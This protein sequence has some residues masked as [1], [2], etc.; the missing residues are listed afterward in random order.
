[1]IK[2]TETN[3]KYY[4]YNIQRK[5]LD[6]PEVITLGNGKTI[7]YTARFSATIVREKKK[8]DEPTDSRLRE[9]ADERLSE[10]TQTTTG[11][12]KYIDF[13][14]LMN[15]SDGLG[16]DYDTKELFF[17]IDEE[18]EYV[19]DNE[20]AGINKEHIT[21]IKNMIKNARKCEYKEY[22]EEIKYRDRIKD[23]YS[24]VSNGNEDRYIIFFL[25]LVNDID[26]DI[27]NDNCHQ[28]ILC[29][30]DTTN[31]R[32][33]VLGDSGSHPFMVTNNFIYGN[34]DGSGPDITQEMNDDYTAGN[35]LA[36]MTKYFKEFASD[37]YH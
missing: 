15:A 19:A 37:D 17:I 6:E 3:K 2:V 14:K 1:M 29:L 9:G 35:I 5:K 7:T 33:I 18:M 8:R 10:S 24:Y 21:A 11:I 20:I 26:N 4:I 25:S 36:M 23:M 22:V 34:S 13:K 27:D 28:H 16:G 30:I 32:Y 12:Q 31:A